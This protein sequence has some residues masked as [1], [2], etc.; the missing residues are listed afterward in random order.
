MI[1]ELDALYATLDEKELGRWLFDE[2]DAESLA[3]CTVYV[4]KQNLDML[5]GLKG[6]L[7]DE[8]DKLM[9]NLHEKHSLECR[10]IFNQALCMGMRLAVLGR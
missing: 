1:K 2:D 8:F 9:N 10:A 5:N 3:D 7:Y 4:A 6:N